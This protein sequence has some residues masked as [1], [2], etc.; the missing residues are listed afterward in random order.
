MK[1][2]FNMKK[3]IVFA[4]FLISGFNAFAGTQEVLDLLENNQDVQAA[5]VE[6]Q[7][8]PMAKTWGG[9]NLRE[10]QVEVIGR[11]FSGGN[12]MGGNG[13]TV[14]YLVTYH[15]GVNMDW[16]GYSDSMLVFVSE[17]NYTA[18][19]VPSQKRILVNAMNLG[20]PASSGIKVDKIVKSAKELAKQK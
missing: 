3:L 17:W 12:P 20:L 9:L 16:N 19:K 1:K 18:L 4:V 13:E 5:L 2:V 10:P 15:Y 14:H 11:D 8:D 6:V 7:N